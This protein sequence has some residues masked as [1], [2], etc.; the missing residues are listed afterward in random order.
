MENFIINIAVTYLIL[1][2]YCCIIT[3]FLQYVASIPPVCAKS[4]IPKS[5][6]YYVVI[7]MPQHYI[8]IFLKQTFLRCCN[9][10]EILQQYIAIFLQYCNKI[11]LHI[12]MYDMSY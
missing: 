11:F 12:F 1:Q 5:Y 10:A 3:M 9:V 8:T 4:N 2:Q 7:Y 6:I